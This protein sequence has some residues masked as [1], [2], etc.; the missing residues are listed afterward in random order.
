MS[1]EKS[2]SEDIDGDLLLN[3]VPRMVAAGLWA[4]YEDPNTTYTL[5]ELRAVAEHLVNGCDFWMLEKPE[6]PTEERRVK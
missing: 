3:V 4:L 5:A 1:E 2:V 6:W